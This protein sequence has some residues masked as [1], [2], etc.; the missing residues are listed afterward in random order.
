MIGWPVCQLCQIAAVMAEDALQDAHGNTCGGTTAVLFES[1]LVFEGVIDRLDVL[2]HGPKQHPAR[3]WCFVAVG[4]PH[5]GDTG[6]VK[7]CFRLAVKSGMRL[8]T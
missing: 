7:P 4:R 8:L 5:N 1:E 3:A 2:P 6:F